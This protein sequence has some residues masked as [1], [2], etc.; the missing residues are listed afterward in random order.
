MFHTYLVKIITEY[1]PRFQ[2][3]LPKYAI[4]FKVIASAVDNGLY[5]V[6]TKLCDLMFQIT[7]LLMVPPLLLMAH[8]FKHLGS[9]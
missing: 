9:L 3:P 4:S 7:V 1:P 5:A 8:R 2:P 6:L